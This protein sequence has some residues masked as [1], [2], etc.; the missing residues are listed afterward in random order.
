MPGLCGASIPVPSPGH[1]ALRQDF[2]N[3]HLLR[4]SLR[5]PAFR[6]GPGGETGTLRTARAGSHQCVV[7]GLGCGVY[8]NC[9]GFGSCVFAGFWAGFFFCLVPFVDP[10]TQARFRKRNPGSKILET[11]SHRRNNIDFCGNTSVSGKAKSIQQHHGHSCENKQFLFILGLR[12]HGLG[13][14]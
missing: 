12:V 14:K 4:L 5:S 13:Y 6:G 3:H 1:R 11:L 9:I 7:Q 10:E 2:G 8:R